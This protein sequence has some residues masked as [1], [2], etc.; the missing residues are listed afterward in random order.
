MC[1]LIG[2]FRKKN[3]VRSAGWS[4]AV[5]GTSSEKTDYMEH[6]HALSAKGEKWSSETYSFLP[7]MRKQIQTFEEA[8]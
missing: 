3:K 6:M 1:D 5:W 4:P 8:S 7:Q 2:S